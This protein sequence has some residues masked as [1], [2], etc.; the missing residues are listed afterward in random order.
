MEQSIPRDHCRLRRVHHAPTRG[1]SSEHTQPARKME[2][3]IHHPQCV[4]IL[5]LNRKAHSVGDL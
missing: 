2:H 5:V 3:P 4:G 1:G